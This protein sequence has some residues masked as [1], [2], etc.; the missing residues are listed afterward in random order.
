MRDVIEQDRGVNAGRLGRIKYGYKSDM[1]STAN[2][3]DGYTKTA[4]KEG[5][6]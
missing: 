2:P 6:R 1:A 5:T 4:K 3:R